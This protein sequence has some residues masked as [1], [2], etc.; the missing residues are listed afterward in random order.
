[1]R[2][3][4]QLPI[5]RDANRLLVLVEEVVRGFARYHKYTLGTELRTLA[6]RLCRSIHR[7]VSR[8]SSR[9]KLIQQ[10]VELVDDLK[11]HLQLAKELKAFARFTQFQQVAELVVGLGRQA[12][13]WYKQ[14][15]AEAH[16]R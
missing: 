8:Q 4:N 14:A 5:W 7:V 6:L 12:G 11:L 2:H 13:G 10:V 16:R 15:R 3:L 1:M 9:L